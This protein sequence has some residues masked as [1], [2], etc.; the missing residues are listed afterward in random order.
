MLYFRTLWGEVCVK[1]DLSKIET[2]LISFA[3]TMSFDDERLDPTRVIGPMEVRLE[4]KVRPAGDHYLVDGRTSASG[5]LSCGRC[6]EPVEWRME[7]GFD[8][9]VA[10]TDA[11]PVDPELALDEADLD[12]V[13]LTEPLLDLEELAIEQVLLE[14]P[15]RVVCSE[16]CAGLCPQCGANRNQEGA[17][18]CQPE[19][20]PRW[21]AL[22]DL[23]GHDPVD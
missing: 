6:L 8:L 22:K 5:H 9:E 16:E 4:G 12:V 23:A 17:C 10:L 14:M 3:E 20:D 13:F 19:A 18:R 11:A 15:I 2:E 21:A 7:S 1:V